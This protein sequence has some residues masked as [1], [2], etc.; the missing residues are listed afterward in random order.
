L[1]RLVL[2]LSIGAEYALGTPL[3][4]E[5]I[6]K[7]QRGVALSVTQIAWALGYVVAA[8]VGYF[9]NDNGPDAWRWLLVSQTVPGALVMFL[10][11]GTP[12]S[13]RWLVSKGRYDEARAIVKKVIGPDVDIEDLINDKQATTVNLGV[14]Y[15]FT[16]NVWRRTAFS[17]LFFS[18]KDSRANS[19]ILRRS[20]GM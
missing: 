12:E 10:R 3:L 9:M 16:R 2:G 13:P 5:F 15:L 20:L 19:N 1:I 17:C 11:I 7:K 8:V 18:C 6:P 14:K 4:V